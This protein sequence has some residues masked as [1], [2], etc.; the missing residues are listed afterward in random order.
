MDILVY[1][2]L[3]VSLVCPFEPSEDRPL[4]LLYNEEDY[5]VEFMIE[6]KIMVTMTVEEY[7]KFAF[8]VAAN[9]FT[10][11]MVSGRLCSQCAR[12]LQPSLIP[13]LHKFHLQMER[14]MMEEP[15]VIH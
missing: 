5:Y 8:L 12:L 11:E 15:Q 7:L 9:R 14:D 3:K 10:F 1:N 4:D 6:G 2:N 13:N